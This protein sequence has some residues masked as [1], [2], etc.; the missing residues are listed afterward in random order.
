MDKTTAIYEKLK[1]RMSHE[2]FLVL[3][4]QKEKL[5]GDLADRESAAMLVACDLGVNNDEMKI[6]KVTSDI[7][8]VTVIGKVIT[9]SDVRT[10]ARDDGSAGSVANLTIADDTG[11]IR[12]VLWDQAADLVKVGEIGFKDSIQVSGFVK[13]GR[14]GLEISIGRGGSVDKVALNEEIQVRIEPYKI[15]EIHSGMSDIHIVGKVL[16]ISDIRTFQRKD[17]TTGR[18]RNITLGDATGKIRVTVWDDK[19]D[20]LDQIAL[21]DNIE[22][23]GAYARENTFSNQVEINTGFNTSIR[24]SNIVVEYEEKIT[25]IAD[26]V[27]NESYSVSGYITGLDEIKEFQRNDGVTG[28]VMNIHIS[29]DTGRIRTSLW[30]KQIDIISEIDIGTKL[31]ITDCYAKPGWN[32]EVELSVGERS[33]ITVLK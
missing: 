11:S 12:V 8:N 33:T 32:N 4:E 6:D 24:K 20:K 16:E 7:S 1:G 5:M 19:I 3:V 23:A 29:D 31:M 13:E 27:P 25:P 21:N 10:F 18:V 28:R 14:N 2:E 15:S 26:I 22:I 9:C 17:A 30:D